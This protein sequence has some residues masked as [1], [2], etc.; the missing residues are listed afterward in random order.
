MAFTF[1]SKRVG[2]DNIA[3]GAAAGFE[4]VIE[5]G[6]PGDATTK[7][8]IETRGVSADCV[9]SS[10]IADR[11]VELHL[12]MGGATS[13]GDWVGQP[14]SATTPYRTSATSFT[15]AISELNTAI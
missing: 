12:G 7:Q 6:G 13:S 1:K 9:A 2:Y 5:G 3:S 11:V 10:Y 4:R 15:S 8:S 14:S